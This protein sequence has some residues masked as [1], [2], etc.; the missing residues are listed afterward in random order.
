MS[1]LRNPNVRAS[2]TRPS[3]ERPSASRSVRSIASPTVDDDATSLLTNEA[4]NFPD[5]D[6]KSSSVNEH[7]H[8]NLS[9]RYCCCCS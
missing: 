5:R 8:K 6:S 9:E 4:S 3:Q 1:C 2:S 7:T